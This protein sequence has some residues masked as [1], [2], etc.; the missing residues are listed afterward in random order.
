VATSKRARHPTG[1]DTSRSASPSAASQLASTASCTSF[2]W[3]GRIQ[4]SPMVAM[5]LRVPACCSPVQL[6]T[7]TRL[8]IPS[9]SRG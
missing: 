3:A 9:K 6:I 7:G 5:P 2:T 4:V 8:K 1:S